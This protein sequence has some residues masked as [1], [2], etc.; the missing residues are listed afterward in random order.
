MAIGFVYYGTRHQQIDD[1]IPVI[2]QSTDIR[3]QVYFIC[4]VVKVNLTS[5]IFMQGNRC[6]KSLYRC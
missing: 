4:V 3:S 1:T 6:I 5:Q 2:I